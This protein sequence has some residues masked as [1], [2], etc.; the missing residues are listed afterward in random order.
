MAA[1]R[2]DGRTDE[3]VSVAELC[4]R[5]GPVPATADSVATGAT[6]LLIGDL[7]RREGRPEVGPDPFAPT[8]VVA[9]PEA[10]RA[11]SSRAVQDD[12]PGAVPVPRRRGEACKTALGA[13]GLVV[14]GSVLG[15][16]LLAAAGIGGALPVPQGDDGTGQFQGQGT[17]RT[18]GTAY[19]SVNGRHV[20]SGAG[21]VRA[22]NYYLPFTRSPAP[23][24][25]P[26]TAARPAVLPASAP[27]ARAAVP[28]QAL[29]PAA[30][31][32]SGEPGAGLPQV[33]GQVTQPVAAGYRGRR[34]GHRCCRLD[35]SAGSRRLVR[36]R[37][38]SS[39]RSTP[40]VSHR[41]SIRSH[42]RA[43]RDP[44]VTP[45]AAAVAPAVAGVTDLV[46]PVAGAVGPVIG[47]VAAPLVRAA[48]PI[49]DPV[50]RATAPIVNAVAP[51]STP[52]VAAAAPIAGPVLA[53]TQPAVGQ[54]LDAAGPGL[55]AV[56][57]LVQ[58]LQDLAE[59]IATR[60]GATG[61]PQGDVSALPTQAIPMVQSTTDGATSTLQD[62][63]AAAGSVVEG[64]TGR[65]RCRHRHRGAVRAPRGRPPHHA[66]PDR[67]RGPH[68]A[69][70]GRLPHDT[71]ADRSAGGR[72]RPVGRLPHAPA[73]DRPA[74][75]SRHRQRTD[76][77]RPERRRTGAHRR[78]G[79]RSRLLGQHRVR[80]VEPRA[81]PGPAA[82]GSATRRRPSPD[83]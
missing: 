34:P 60:V 7:L 30:V 75:A 82:A 57:P 24:A 29:A 28:A 23:M 5:L 73:Q 15:A 74:R 19:G 43:P 42:T 76:G 10:R 83:C 78:S 69:R 71:A 56:G 3:P 35:R 8:P 25:A 59:P 9:V 37:Q 38:P 1:T 36:R 17:L 79:Q 11:P 45:V 41:P 77:R 58:P 53:A 46:Q 13:G 81:R 51:A 50:L 49:L 44:V 22:V 65:R 14:A 27:V 18:P 12:D 48:T 40:V 33:V 26:M 67:G 20:V 61:L 80:R 31:P 16:A 62:A 39:G 32:A 66:A 63:T 68:A 72:A 64:A 70:G 54:V 21:L 6:P 2:G 4:R 52:I 47:P 55:A